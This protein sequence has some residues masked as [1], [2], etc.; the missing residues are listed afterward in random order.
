MNIGI[1]PKDAPF[2][3]RGVEVRALVENICGLA[4]Y[5]EP[6]SKTFWN[7]QLTMVIG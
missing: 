5:T 3:T 6:M 4:Q 7:E 1:G 2:I